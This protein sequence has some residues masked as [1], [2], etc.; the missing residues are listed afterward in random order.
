MA[1]GANVVAKQAPDDFVVNRQR[2]LREDRI[3]ELLELLEDVVVEAGI[4][5][6][7]PSQQD[8]ADAVLGFELLQDFAAL[9]AQNCP[10]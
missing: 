8:D 10:R 2:T 9:L 1:A 4:V 7:R 5:V 6:I 3:A